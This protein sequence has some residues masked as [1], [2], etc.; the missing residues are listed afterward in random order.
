M[1]LTATEIAK[2]VDQPLSVVEKALKSLEE[3]GLIT[4]VEDEWHKSPERAT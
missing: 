4:T 3:K 2:L 1:G